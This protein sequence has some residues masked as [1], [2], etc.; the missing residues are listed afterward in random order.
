MGLG[1]L[2]GWAERK[3]GWTGTKDTQ[4][5]MGSDQGRTK[6]ASKSQKLLLKD[7]MACE[8]Y[9]CLGLGRH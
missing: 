3:E 9:M 1:F 8:F 4:E 5:G 6:W 2:A 7:L